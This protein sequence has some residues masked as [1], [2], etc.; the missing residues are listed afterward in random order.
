MRGQRI[1]SPPSHKL[2][3][4]GRGPWLCPKLRLSRGSALP[5]RVLPCLSSITGNSPRS[6]GDLAVTGGRQ[7][8]RDVVNTPLGPEGENVSVEAGKQR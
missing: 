6:L 4:G 1:I 3:T 8:R 7:A 2:G 5:A